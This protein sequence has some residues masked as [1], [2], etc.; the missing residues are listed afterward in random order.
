MAIQVHTF[1]YMYIESS[2]I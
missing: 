1:W 2:W